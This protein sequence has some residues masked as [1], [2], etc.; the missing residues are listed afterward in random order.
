MFDQSSLILLDEPDHTQFSL[1]LPECEC[2]PKWLTDTSP[3]LPLP[4]GSVGA[5]VPL[6]VFNTKPQKD[7][8]EACI[9][10]FGWLKAVMP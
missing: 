4:Q 10:V 8:H 7:G 6:L 1:G 2:L 5:V 3:G 9:F